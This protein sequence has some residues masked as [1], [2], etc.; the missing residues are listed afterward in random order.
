MKKFVVF[1]TLV[2]ALVSVL[3]VFAQSDQLVLKIKRDF[4]Y[5]GFDNQ[6]EG[7]FTVSAEGP[8][9]LVQVDFYIDG[10]PM[11][12]VK[13]AP[14][15]FQFS[16]G[17]YAPGEHHLTA[18][19]TRADGSQLQSNE[20]V[21]VFLTKAESDRAV[22][23]FV[24]P[25]LAGIAVL[26]VVGVLFMVLTGRR[27]SFNGSYGILGGTVCPKCGLPYSLQFLAPRFGFSRLQRCPHCGKWALVH[28]AKP[29]ELAAAEARWRG[30]QPAATDEAEDE[31]TR[32]QIDDSRY[33]A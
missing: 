5:G 20:V 2:L 29:E 25:L 11:A 24:V 19:G 16:T 30:D 23:G 9:D 33:D 21:R 6:I 22:V 1:L 18:R 26:V 12:S 15:S 10:A 28:R 32:R 14:F 8:D 27:A 13:Q 31:R 4:G 7:L 3:P 17:S